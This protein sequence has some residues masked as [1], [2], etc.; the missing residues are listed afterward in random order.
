MPGYS[1]HVPGVKC[2]TF[3]GESFSKTTERALN[4]NSSRERMKNMN[5]YFTDAKMTYTPKHLSYFRRFESP[6]DKKDI[7]AR[8]DDS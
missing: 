5:H 8:K 7:D 1:G 6:A 2:E 3:Y 4:E